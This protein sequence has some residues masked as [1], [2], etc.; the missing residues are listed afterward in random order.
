MYHL[1]SVAFGSFV[2][3]LVKLPRAILLYIDQKRVL[4]VSILNKNLKK[5]LFTFKGQKI[6]KQS[7][8]NLFS[9]VVNAVCGVWKRL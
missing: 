1:G 6:K 8:P 7:V 3:L 2:I 5:N 9:S 4:V